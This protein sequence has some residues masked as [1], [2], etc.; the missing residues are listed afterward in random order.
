MSEVSIGGKIKRITGL[1]MADV[2]DWE[3]K[4]IRDIDVKTAGG[5]RTTHLSEAQ[6]DV[7]DRIFDKHFAA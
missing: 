3:W 1:M 6:C 5:D 2:T 7:I 4:F